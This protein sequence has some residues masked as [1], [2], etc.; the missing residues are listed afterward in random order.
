MPTERLEGIIQFYEL[1]IVFDSIKHPLVDIPLH[2]KTALMNI[3]INFNSPRILF[4]DFSR[5]LGDLFVK[6]VSRAK[7]SRHLVKCDVTQNTHN[8]P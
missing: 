7:L 5:D 3:K 2:F 6:L 4:V 1:A 8:N